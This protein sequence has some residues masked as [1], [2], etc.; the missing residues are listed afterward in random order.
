MKRKLILTILIL[1]LCIIPTILSIQTYA[2][3][4]KITQT[5]H[6]IT[7]P[8]FYFS[9]NASDINIAYSNLTYDINI[10]NFLG[11]KYSTTDI[12][13]E[14]S[15]SDGEGASE[16]YDFE[17]NG[18][19]LDDT[20]TYKSTISGNKKNT[21]SLNIKFSR[22]TDDPPPTETLYFTIKST[23][24]FFK[25]H[26]YKV[27]II[28]P[29]GFNVLGNPTD[30]TNQDV[31]LTVVP[32][33]GTN[34]I[35]YSFDDGNTWQTN[36]SKV[37]SSNQEVSIKIK[38]ETGN[39]SSAVIPITKIDKVSPTIT[40]IEAI[41]NSSLDSNPL[42]ATLD[43]PSYGTDLATATDDLS[44]INEYS[45]E[46]YIKNGDTPTKIENTNY[47]TKVGWY[48]I[49][50][51]ATDRAGNKTI[52]ETSV[53]VRWPTAGKYVVK[54]QGYIGEGVSN[55]E[56]GAGLWKD[57][58]ETGYD[59]GIPYSS[60]YYYSG[61]EVNNYVNFSNTTF[62][63]LNIA[64]ND[65]IKLI[66]PLS[67]NSYGWE[68]WYSKIY[69]TSFYKS[70]AGDWTP[71]NRIYDED[72][73]NKIDVDFTSENSHIEEATFYAGVME[74]DKDY[75]I[76]DLITEERTN[77]KKIHGGTAPY[78]SGKV[79][80]PTVSDYIKANSSLNTIYNIRLTQ[81]N[82]AVFKEN[83]YLG[84]DV[85]QFT[86]TGSPGAVDNDFWVLYPNVGNEIL[87]RTGYYNQKVRAVIYLK[88]NTILSGIGTED[89]PF[90]VQ[91][92]WDWFDSAQTLE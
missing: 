40:P 18:E 9:T 70:W 27:N 68:A 80:L 58:A 78:F 91:E 71:N 39:I 17:I 47:F 29:A 59:E 49:Y 42:T 34:V 5:T 86:M 77:D 55:L 22:L 45:I 92:N 62:Q 90:T 53:L 32:D 52:Y 64:S 16:N 76:L 23:Y 75:T 88:N 74:R 33:E 24:P 38:D 69:K 56:I 3:Y 37:F 30:W 44:G 26:T 19:K 60:K 43:D 46:I 21:Q 7:T 85:E 31:T 84:S 79:A 25:S 1:V 4:A 82:S 73:K 6:Y 61:K 50:L 72:D 51:Q 41:Q 35:E 14:I 11:S 2:R 81:T 54:R 83:N 48:K 15:I 20:D 13:Y 28:A 8:E 67:S 36:P 57:T 63:I 65:T 87:S 12:N 66:S 10:Y 89:D